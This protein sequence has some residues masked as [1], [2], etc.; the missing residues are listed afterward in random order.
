[1]QS[2]KGWNM[3]PFLELTTVLLLLGQVTWTPLSQ[4][5]RCGGSQLPSRDVGRIKL[6]VIFKAPST[7]QMLKKWEQNS[8]NRIEISLTKNNKQAQR[9]ICL[10]NKWLQWSQREG[11]GQNQ[12]QLKLNVQSHLMLSNWLPFLIGPERL[13][14]WIEGIFVPDEQE[15]GF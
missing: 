9:L 3:A 10:I 14:G 7:Q 5:Q 8:W 15:S 4:S 2:G 13:H 6:S 12:Y 1:M 11:E